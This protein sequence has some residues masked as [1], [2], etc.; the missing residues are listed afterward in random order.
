MIYITFPV[1]GPSSQLTVSYPLLAIEGSLTEQLD[2]KITVS[3]K[4]DHSCSAWPVIQ[5]KFKCFLLLNPKT[6]VIVLQ[7]GFYTR[8]I[9]VYRFRDSSEFTYFIQPL[10]VIFKD[11]DGKFQAP[12]STDNSTNGAVKRLSLACALV[13]TFTAANLSKLL[14]IEPNYTFQFTYDST[15]R[16]PECKVFRS[17]H[18]VGDVS[19]LTETELWKLLAKELMNSN[20]PHLSTTKF[21]MFLSNT[22]YDGTNWNPTWRH[23]DI[24]SATQGYAAMGKSYIL[25]LLLIP[26][27][28]NII[29]MLKSY[30]HCRTIT[31]AAITT[32]FM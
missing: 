21:I 32:N 8:T 17:K 31:I 27:I 10:Y 18:S 2:D 14:N 19:Q 26:D 28:Y 6:N 7:H 13:Q 15:T 5:G 29:T 1:L 23:R 24:V 12:P 22:R 9:N 4:A 3:N 16:L 20:L 11:S 25:K 30:Y